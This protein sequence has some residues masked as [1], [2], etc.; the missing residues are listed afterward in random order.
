MHGCESFVGHELS[1]YRFACPSQRQHVLEA[2]DCIFVLLRLRKAVGHLFVSEHLA[3]DIP[4]RVSAVTQLP[5]QFECQDVFLG[6]EEH[7]AE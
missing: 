4:M 7:L 3:D 5:V 6:R 1:L 2:D